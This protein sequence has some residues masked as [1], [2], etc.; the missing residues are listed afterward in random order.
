MQTNNFTYPVIV[1]CTFNNSYTRSDCPPI[2]QDCQPIDTCGWFTPSPEESYNCT[3]CPT[4]EEFC[5]PYI[6]GDKIPMQVYL[7]DLVNPEPQN[8]SDGWFEGFGTSTIRAQL[9]NSNGVVVSDNVLD[10]CIE[11]VVGWNGRATYQTIIIDTS[12][13]IF[14]TLTCW[15]IRINNFLSDATTED[16]IIYSEPFCLATQ[17]C[18]ELPLVEGTFNDGY[19]CLGFYYGLAEF[20][21]PGQDLAYTGT[22]DFRYYNS[23]RYWADFRITAGQVQKDTFGDNFVSKSTVF[24][25][26]TFSTTK[27]V[28]DYIMCTFLKQHLG[29]KRFF[30]DGVE[31][32]ASGSINNRV[33]D[34]NMFLWEL[35]VQKECENRFNCF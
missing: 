15:S 5:I 35:T 25:N 21:R 27:L 20:R 29:A 31:Y 2:R 11:Y 3:R 4:D 17:E 19:D 34:N 22:S 30:I 12:N 7:P 16:K 26:Y 10:F 13:A 8:P 18:T 23:M 1:A 9:L 28:P 32:I 6:A 14:N 24:Q 33:T